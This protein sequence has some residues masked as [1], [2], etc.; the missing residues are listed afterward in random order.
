MNHLLKTQQTDRTVDS[1]IWKG[2]FGAIAGV[3]GWMLMADAVETIARDSA[4]MSALF[5]LIG[6][7]AMTGGSAAL[8]FLDVV[9]DGEERLQ[10]IGMCDALR[11]LALTV[12]GAGVAAL[13]P[14]IDHAPNAAVSSPALGRGMIGSALIVGDVGVALL[15]VRNMH[16]DRRSGKG[17]K[18]DVKGATMTE[19]AH[20]TV[21]APITK[22]YDGQAIIEMALVLMVV[23]VVI[24]GGVAAVQSI[25]AHYTVSQAVRVAAHQAALRGSTG[26]LMFNQ[27]YPLAS[28]PGPVAEAA[29]TAFAGSVFAEPQHATIQVHCAT[30]PC[31]RYS[32]ITVTIG[33]TAEV[34]TPIPGLSNIHVN[35]S[36]TRTA[37]QDT[38]N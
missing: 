27:E 3:S 12:I 16:R 19:N 28:A 24:F 32:T 31:R 5:G 22:R 9:A 11:I 1:G 23:L 36:A 25:G 33:Y 15:S 18:A 35:R 10:P 38:D 6:V 7:G 13:T 4:D 29:R 14:A 26:G 20:R 34:W 2:L 8:A 30:T 21:G 37:E 17:N